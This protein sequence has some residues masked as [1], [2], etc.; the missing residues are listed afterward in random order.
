MNKKKL[1]LPPTD[2][3]VYFTADVEQNSTSDLIA[4]LLSLQEKDD[5]QDIVLFI[6]S[7]GGMVSLS[8]GV[9]DIIDSLSCNVITVCA[10]YC[11]SAAVLIFAAGTKGKR[12]ITA[13]SELMLHHVIAPN[14]KSKT[15]KALDSK[16]EDLK[17]LNDRFFT[18]LA[19]YYGGDKNEFIRLYDVGNCWIDT[20]TIMNRGL[21]DYIVDGIEF[22][23]G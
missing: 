4:N 20:N 21:A 6:C 9:C 17:T 12:F 22:K 3:H 10:G 18:K 7:N 11:A 23:K 14:T 13:N 19:N 2:R 15:I 8:L 5:Q 1:I 16:L